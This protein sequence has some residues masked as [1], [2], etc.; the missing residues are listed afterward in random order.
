MQN[1]LVVRVALGTVFSPPLN[2]KSFDGDRVASFDGDRVALSI[3][4]PLNAKSFGGDSSFRCSFFTFS[5]LM[6]NHL[7]VTQ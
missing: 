3:F 6:Q 5:L 1:H 2:T 4:P 7:V